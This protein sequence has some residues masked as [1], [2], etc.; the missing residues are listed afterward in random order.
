MKTLKERLGIISPNTTV[1]D[2]SSLEYNDCSIVEW[3]LNDEDLKV[4]VS[5]MDG[6]HNIEV[7]DI[8]DNNVYNVLQWLKL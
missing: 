1:L 6:F 2:L 7:V 5:Q 8:S 4:V 3:K